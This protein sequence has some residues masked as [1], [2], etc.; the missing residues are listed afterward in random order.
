MQGVGM[1]GVQGI[2]GMGMQG[3]DVEDVKMG[4]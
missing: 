1:Q 4:T 2:E 3:G